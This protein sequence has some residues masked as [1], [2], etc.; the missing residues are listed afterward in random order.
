MQLGSSSL[1]SHGVQKVFP[2]SFWYVFLG[3]F[4]HG[5]RPVDDL[6]FG[7]HTAT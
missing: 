2:Y 3:Q 5:P 1:L 4:S 6:V 7:V